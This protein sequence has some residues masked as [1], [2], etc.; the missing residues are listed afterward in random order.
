MAMTLLLL[1]GGL[2][3]LL[4]G[5]ELLVRAGTHLALRL[6]L[7]PLVIGATIVA[8]GTSTPELAVG[9]DAVRSGSGA[10]AIANIAGTN[11]FNILF[12]LGLSAAMKPLPLRWETLRLDLPMI[13]VASA[14]MVVFALDASFS[15]AEGVV[16]LVGAAIYT[17]GI[18]VLAARARRSPL[19]HPEIELARASMAPV[20]RRPSPVTNMGILLV[21]IAV[22]VA[23]SSWLVDG[24]VQLAR[25][26]G[27]SETL[28]GLT[29]IAIGTS[30]PELAT[31]ILST[32]RN[33]RD[34]AIGNLIGSSAYN[35]FFI[36]GVTCL[37]IESP[38]EVEPEVLT[39]DLPI[40]L[41]VSVLCIPLFFSGRRLARI[42]GVAM[43]ILFL[44]Y[45]GYLLWLRS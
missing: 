31:T 38:I 9:I 1:V 44:A 30:S 33:Q 11:V 28:I 16:L 43:V 6:G 45:M 39:V 18:V 34:I 8:I 15:R 25:A 23:G 13:V 35:I 20:P 26:W 42:E 40:M 37:F 22:V 41:A 36:F 32:L 7:S 4:G 24:A 17:L 19:Q 29:V 27:V 2:A 3:A 14:I 5:A 21:G 12:I 10:L